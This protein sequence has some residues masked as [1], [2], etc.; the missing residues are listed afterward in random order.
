MVFAQKFFI[1]TVLDAGL[2]Q[3]LCTEPQ[4]WRPFTADKTAAASATA[5]ARTRL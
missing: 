3:S 2:E 5:D 1:Q 4:T